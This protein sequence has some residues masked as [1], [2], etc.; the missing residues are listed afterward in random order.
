M[1]TFELAECKKQIDEM[2]QKGWIKESTS[3]YGHPL[4]F[5]KKKDGTMCMCVDFCGLNANTRVERYP[6]PRI[7]NLMDRMNGAQVFSAIDLRAGYHQ[8]RIKDDHTHFTAFVSRWGLYKYT[9]LPF[10]L[11]NAPLGF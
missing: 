5:V 2:L 9:I 6:I 1:S 7:D 3:E 8:M 10:G 11:V 4:L